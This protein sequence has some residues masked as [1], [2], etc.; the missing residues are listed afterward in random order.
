MLRTKTI[1]FSKFNTIAGKITATNLDVGSSLSLD[2]INLTAYK[3]ADKSGA[4]GYTRVG[5][6]GLFVKK[7]VFDFRTLDG[8]DEGIVFDKSGF[9]AYEDDGSLKVDINTSGSLYFKDAEIE[10]HLTINETS[11]RTAL[12]IK[13]MWAPGIHAG[14]VYSSFGISSLSSDFNKGELHHLAI[15]PNYNNNHNG[16]VEI[17]GDLEI[18][19]R[20]N[21]V[22]ALQ[23][24]DSVIS[25]GSSFNNKVSIDAAGDV[26]RWRQ[27]Q[28]NYIS[29]DSDNIKFY[30]DGYSNT[31]LYQKVEGSM[32]HSI[33]RLG[34]SIIKGLDSSDGIQIKNT[35]DD[36]YR[37]IRALDFLMPSKRKYKE[38]IEEFTQSGIAIMKDLQIYSFN[39]KGKDEDFDRYN[40]GRIS[41]VT[42]R[43]RK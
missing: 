12:F 8:D 1:D 6:E 18:Y 19:D 4:S 43:E 28:Y 39:F 36:G 33:I 41:V 9:R 7:G 21:S 11:K 37:A 35:T 30:F 26:A 34:A 25:I 16:T 31:Y 20:E 14:E 38:N 15:V 2:G 42:Q 22:I 27:S 3:N 40:M 29:Q 24:K 32:H 17:Q 10:N 13:P 5:S 23:I